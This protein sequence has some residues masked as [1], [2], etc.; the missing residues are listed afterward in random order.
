M[1]VGVQRKSVSLKGLG[2]MVTF[3]LGPKRCGGIFRRRRGAGHS[4]L[5]KPV[6]ISVVN[7]TTGTNYVN[8]LRSHG[9][10]KLEMIQVVL[11]HHSL[12][13]DSG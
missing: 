10:I 5:Q 2:A 8:S 12:A 3:K 6:I 9:I 13:G 7:F 11:S 1:L 4:R